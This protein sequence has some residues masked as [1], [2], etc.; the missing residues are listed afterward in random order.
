LLS[1]W[2][3]KLINKQG[4]WQE[5]LQNKYLKNKTLSHVSAKP[6]DLQFCKSLMSVKDDFLEEGS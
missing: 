5:L 6:I 4:V 1:K 3:F 2:L